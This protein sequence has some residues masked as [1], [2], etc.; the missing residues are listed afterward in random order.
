[1]VSVHLF[2][3]KD[4]ELEFLLIKRATLSYNWQYVTG[5]RK[6]GETPL[7]SAKRESFKETGYIPAIILPID[8]P[9][10]AFAEND[11]EEGDKFPPHLQKFAEELKINNFIARIDQLKDPVLNPAEHTDWMWCDFE[12]A[13]KLIKWSVGKKALRSIYDYLIR[14]PLK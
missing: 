14:N 9:Q 13:Y 10:E 2:R 6:E 12:T 3:Y 4:S 5:A 8:I 11:E 7:E 1:M